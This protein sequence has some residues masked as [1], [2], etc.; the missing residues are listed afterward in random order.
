MNQL[1]GGYLDFVQSG[2]HRAPQRI[3]LAQFLQT[4]AMRPATTRPC[5]SAVRTW[6]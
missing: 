3:E 6:P 1:I 5:N 4:C 2:V